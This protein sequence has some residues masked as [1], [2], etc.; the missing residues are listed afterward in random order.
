MHIPDKLAFLAGSDRA[1]PFLSLPFC[2]AQMNDKMSERHASS[3]E[4]NYCTVE[5]SL[6]KHWAASNNKLKAIEHYTMDG[7]AFKISLIR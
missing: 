2:P 5:C 7:P 1:L 4:K 3:S 6:G